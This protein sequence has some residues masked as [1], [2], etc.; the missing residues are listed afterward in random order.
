MVERVAG[1]GGPTE[2]PTAQPASSAEEP[3]STGRAPAPVPELV[4]RGPDSRQA[5]PA[6]SSLLLR[7]LARHPIASLSGLLLVLGLVTGCTVMVLL[8]ERSDLA[9]RR[10]VS[11]E[12]AREQ[13]RGARLMRS[14]EER[15]QVLTNALSALDRRSVRRADVEA[16][17]VEVRG[18]VDKAVRGQVDKA[19]AAFETSVRTRLHSDLTRYIEHSIE[20]NP[21]LAEARATVKRFNRIDTAVETILERYTESICIIQGAYGFA[22][23]EQGEWR[24]LREVSHELLEKLGHVGDRVPL[25][26]EGDGPVFRIDYTGTG[27]MA[28]SSGLVLTNRH[29]AE[30]WWKNDDAAPFLADGFEPR[31]IVLRAYFPGRKLAVNFDTSKTITSDRVD[32]AVLNCK[33]RDDLPGPLPLAAAGDL[34]VG[35]PVLLLGYPSGLRA[36]LAKAGEEF[37]DANT[38]SEK[39]DPVKILDALARADMVRPLPTEGRI[40]DVLE[41]KVLYDAPTAVGA[42]GGPVFNREG[43]VVAVNFGILNG[44]QSANFGVPIRY[45]S[46]LLER[47]KLK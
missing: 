19:M 27:F 3:G 47:A 22:R 46:E 12:R 25:T 17:V 41:T 10:E 16:Q 5:D 38:T 29:I 30:P 7:L 21:D 26:L 8:A 23:E 13:R 40:G 42:S 37:I 1:P 20:H 34:R 11:A 35:R 24:F 44:F 9:W 43:R 31:F 45:A 33:E 32:M 6:A 18:E 14:Y 15:I 39:N 36:L 4:V 2:S 28:D